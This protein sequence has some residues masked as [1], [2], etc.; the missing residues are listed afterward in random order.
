MNYAPCDLPG[1]ISLC[2]RLPT[3]VTHSECLNWRVVMVVNLVQNSFLP[4]ICLA[5]VAVQFPE[6]M[7]H[8]EKFHSSSLFSGYSGPSR[9]CNPSP[10]LL[11]FF[12]IF[13][14]IVC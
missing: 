11:G 13:E 10:P 1:L 3:S 12:F 6:G 7:S 9:C 8:S 5:S 4:L 2:L 14:G